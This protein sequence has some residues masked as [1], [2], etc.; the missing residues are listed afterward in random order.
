MPSRHEDERGVIQDL[1]IG[2]IDAVTE[3]IS[4]VGAVRGNH[5]HDHTVQWAYVVRGRLLV[6]TKAQRTAPR[7]F[8]AGQGELFCDKAGVWHA[9]KALE[10]SVVLVFTTGPRSGEGYENDVTR[11][12]PEDRLL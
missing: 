8:E 1:L 4:K 3:I 6:A 11:L 9:W 7:Q 10:D 2:R 12:D 5:K